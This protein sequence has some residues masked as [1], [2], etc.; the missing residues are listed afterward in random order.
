MS[1]LQLVEQKLHLK[2]MNGKGYIRPSV[3]P[4]GALV[5]FLKKKD[6]TLR[7]YIDYRELNKGTIKNMYTLLWI[8]ELL[9]QLKG[10]E[11]FLNIELRSRY[12]QVCI[13]EEDICNTTFHARYGDCDFVV[14]FGISNAPEIFMCLMNNV[15]HPYLY[16]FLI[17]FINDILIYSNNEE[18]MQI[19]QKQY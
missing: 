7:L 4:Q 8:N 10:E 2:E 6:N 15:L 5:L 17:V 12:H 13:K 19:N 14:L 3:S 9:V 1:T 11:V 18:S 16:T